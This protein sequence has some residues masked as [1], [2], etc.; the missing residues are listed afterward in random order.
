MIQMPSVRPVPWA[1]TSG[2]V[3]AVSPVRPA[4]SVVGGKQ[5]ATDPAAREQSNVPA[6]TSSTA[7]SSQADQAATRRVSGSPNAQPMDLARERELQREQARKIEEQADRD[8]EAIERLREVLTNVWE[9]SAAVVEQ[10]LNEGNEGSLTSDTSP[11]LGAL[12]GMQRARRPLVSADK[13]LSQTLAQGGAAN[14]P[15]DPP[16]ADGTVNSADANGT[17]TAPV[18]AYDER[19][20][21][22]PDRPGAGQIISQRV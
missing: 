4:Q 11:D 3:Q 19:G 17:G 2:G 5:E 16:T 7:G 22:N 15:G 9:A 18:L 20:L 1:A 10:A 21:G 13:S 14:L 8:R 6:G 12:A